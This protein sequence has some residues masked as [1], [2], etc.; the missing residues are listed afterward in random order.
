MLVPEALEAGLGPT[1]IVHDEARDDFVDQERVPA[2]EEEVKLSPLGGSLRG[3]HEARWEPGGHRSPAGSPVPSVPVVC[4]ARSSSGRSTTRFSI[5]GSP[6]EPRGDVKPSQAGVALLFKMTSEP[7]LQADGR[8]V[9]GAGNVAG[10]KPVPAEAASLP[11]RQDLN[12][13]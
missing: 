3:R 8:L 12:V 13:V 1:A 7:I 9:T 2:I 6:P 11:Q 10:E 5:G 4:A